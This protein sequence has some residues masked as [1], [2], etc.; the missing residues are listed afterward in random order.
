MIAAG[1]VVVAVVLSK[2]SGVVPGVL[3]AVVA[4][5]ASAALWQVRLDRLTGAART[6]EL[7][8]AE[9]I[10]V[11]SGPAREGGVAQF[12]RPEEEVVS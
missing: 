2:L 7:E 4:G 12:L 5:V 11:L 1:A 3:V 8:K 9:K 6:A 10:Y